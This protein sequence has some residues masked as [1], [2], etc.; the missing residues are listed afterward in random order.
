MTLTGFFNGTPVS[1]LVDSGSQ[2]DILSPEIVHRAGIEVEHLVAPLIADLGAEG[3][4]VRLAVFARADFSSGE[5][6]LS[7][8]PFFV[9]RLPAGID[10]ILG[11][12]WLHDTGM[13]VSSTSV[14]AVP[15]GPHAPVVDLKLGRFALQPDLNFED[16]GFV[17]RDMSPDESHRFAV[18]SILAGIEDS[19][20]YIGYEPHNPLIDVADDD[21]L[22]PDI[23][24]AEF[25]VACDAL[26][27]EFADTLV[28]EL[29]HDRPAPFRPVNHSI[30]IIDESVKTRPR[31]YP[32]PDKYK[33]QWSA[34]ANKFVESGWWSPQALDSACAMFAVPK[35][36][37]AEA[38]FVVNLKPRNANTVKMHTPIPDMRQIRN[39][40]A[41][42]PYRTKLDFKN[43]FEQIRVV[44]DHV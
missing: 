16:L 31:T 37:R 2:A 4:Q 7:S 42:H 25:T 14:F 19:P 29:P 34:H 44:P 1:C 15:N 39:T 17:R 23:S 9:H 27:A 35:H 3:H 33:A 6:S 30:P 38:R 21:P 18:C 43:A 8:R 22:Q 28:D 40:V 41:A 11:L 13:A 36:D 24:H 26:L 12:P 5:I 20:D 10:A 32:M